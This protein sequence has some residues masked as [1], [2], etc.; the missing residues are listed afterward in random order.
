MMKTVVAADVL[1]G[2]PAGSWR[3]EDWQQHSPSPQSTRITPQMSI[4]RIRYS[5]G[6]YCAITAGN[7]GS[8]VKNTNMKIQKM[9][10]FRDV[11]PIPKSSYLY[12]HHGE[13][14]QSHKCCVN[15]QE[16]S[17]YQKGNWSCYRM[18]TGTAGMIKTMVAR[19]R[20]YHAA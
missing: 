18:E 11:I 5:Q 6:P 10:T 17:H 9:S 14:I 8:D 3:F 16:D 20:A 12:S 7:I 4:P 15:A 19:D 13:N 1:V 2:P